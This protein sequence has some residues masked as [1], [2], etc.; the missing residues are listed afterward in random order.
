[1]SPA[2]ITV[3]AAGTALL[4]PGAAGAAAMPDAGAPTDR[5]SLIARIVRPTA[6]HTAADGRSPIR[7]RLRTEAA[8]AGGP[9]GLMV[10]GSRT[11]ASGRTWLRV[12]VPL[13]PN[14]TSAWVDRDDVQVV[15]TAWRVRVDVRARR[16]TVLRAGRAVRSSRIVVGAPGTPTPRGDFAI[17]ELVRQPR[18]AVIGPWALHLTAFSKVLHAYDG[19]PGRIAL[20]GR[21]G[22]LLGD[23]LGSA[24]SHGCV[25][26][27]SALV[28]WLAARLR[29][30][31]PVELR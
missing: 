1:M 13:R 12:A 5:T 9:V 22:A 24:R 31:V 7:V 28:R 29:P 4:L 18:G 2:R 14:G 8:W 19:G 16:L 26:M 25:R 3:V 21:E 17:S 23:P 30:G 27:P 10:L 6:A 11:S 20:H 15:R